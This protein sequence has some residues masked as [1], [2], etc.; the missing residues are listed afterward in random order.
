[1]ETLQVVLLVAALLSLP[2]LPLDAAA[3]TGP[4]EGTAAKP[5]I[6]LMVADDRF[7][8]RCAL[9]ELRERLLTHGQTRKLPA[10]AWAFASTP[11]TTS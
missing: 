10:I 1:M 7:R 8:P 11:P 4:G 3:P 5:N 9:S 6:M 2:D